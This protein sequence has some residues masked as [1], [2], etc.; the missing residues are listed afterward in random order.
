MPR[1]ALTYIA[2]RGERV[3]DAPHRVGREGDEGEVRGEGVPP[4][5]EGG[6]S[7]PVPEDSHPL[8]FSPKHSSTQNNTNDKQSSAVSEA[9]DSTM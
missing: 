2:E 6:L 1:T 3:A 8:P 7:E 4:G 9:S 5:G